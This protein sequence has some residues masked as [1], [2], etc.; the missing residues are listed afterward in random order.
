MWDLDGTCVSLGQ[1]MA[2][3]QGKLNRSAD[4]CRDKYREM[5]DDYIKG[6]W[7]EQETEVLKRLIREQVG[8]EPN[9]DL[10]DVAKL[11]EDQNIQIPWSTISKRMGK[12]SRLSCFKKWQKLTGLGGDDDALD[13]EDL[14]LK[15][16]KMDA[17]MAAEQEVILDEDG[18]ASKRS[19]TEKLSAFAVMDHHSNMMGDGTVGGDG[20]V[21]D[22]YESAKMADETVAALGLPDTR[23]SFV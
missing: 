4:A 8:V 17:T 14:L 3:I 2:T 6:R 20:G 9:T 23:E 19:K 7:K 13:G 11:V 21:V 18:P 16:D 22:D 10:K 12:R 15:E 5:S 1:K